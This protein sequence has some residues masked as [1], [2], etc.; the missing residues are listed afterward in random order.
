MKA[1]II[2]G[3]IG[4]LSA[5]MALRASGVEV[6]VYEQASALREVG[7][8][9][10]ITPNATRI[11]HRFGLA[12]ELEAVGTRTQLLQYRRWED[13]RTLTQQ[14]LGKRIEERYGAPY[15]H[16]HRSDLLAALIKAVPQGIVRLAHRCTGID[17]GEDSVG[18]S[19]ENGR[20]L[21][22]DLVVGADGM[23]SIVRRAIHGADAPRF[24]GD[25]SFRGL[26]RS[27]RMPQLAAALTQNIWLGGNQHFV[28]TFAGP[29]YVN[30]I[31]LVQG[32]ASEESW[33]AKGD[34]KELRAMFDSWDPLVHEMIDS[35]DA[36]MRWALYDRDPLE[37]WGKGRVTLLGDAAHPMLPY[38]AQ[39]AGQSIEDAAL[40]AKCLEKKQP[41]EAQA[42][43]REY[44]RLRTPRTSKI[45]V[46]ARREGRIYHL[47]DGE[48]QRKRDASF[49][50]IVG[51]N[52]QRDE[53]LFGYDVLADYDQR[54][55][56]GRHV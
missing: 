14:E 45:Q 51:A 56:H 22:A 2:G 26:V 40:L 33:S 21:S 43:L 37:H 27:E 44:E 35:A 6:E 42:A 25:V 19:F 54:S 12:E 8:G 28:Q 50:T 9:L 13:G 20:K 24:S 32:E 29:R 55:A 17:I 47:P 16:F 1:L 5:A 46:G 3:G 48:E 36:I 18:V 30:F 4:G 52:A 49:E 10:R 23:H 39:G 31:A 15:Y 41:A 38:L 34:A 7:A 53:W 11:L